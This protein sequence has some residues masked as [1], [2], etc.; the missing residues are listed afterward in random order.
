[1]RKLILPAI[2]A[3]IV[4]AILIGLGM[5]QLERLAW[6]ENLIAQ[7]SARMTAKPVSA[8]G[9]LIWSG[10]NVG[11]L[12]YQ[13]VTVSGKFRNDKEAHV[14]YTLTAPKG[15][16]SGV[17]YAVMTPFVTDQGWIV[18][19]NRGFV[20]AAKRDPA[21]RAE[22]QIEGETTVVG[23]V[24]GP[25]DRSWFM[26]GDDAAKNEWFSR[27]PTLYATAAG[28]PANDVA[29]YIIDAKFD[30][31]LPGGLPQGGETIIDFPNNHL[32]YAIT[33]FGLAACC[34]GVFAVFAAGKLRNRA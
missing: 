4:C 28:L 25:A 14:I 12:E 31:S 34:A 17:G 24:R 21:T 5:W 27:D 7:V 3:A 19:I 23:L 6:K 16:A 2:A 18:Y 26:P 11:A 8:P 20:P 33:W 10:L 1:M 15:P 30:P 29:P 22:G 9:P 32:G 13:P